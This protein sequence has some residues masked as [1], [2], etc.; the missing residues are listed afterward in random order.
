[1]RFLEAALAL[2][3]ACMSC[4]SDLDTGGP[5]R[6]K[7][8][9]AASAGSQTEAS[10]PIEGQP[11]SNVAPREN[12]EAPGGFLLENDPSNATGE[13]G[14]ME[15]NACAVALFQPREAEVAIE[16][17]VTI[18]KEV[19]TPVSLYIVLDNSLSMAQAGVN[20]AGVS[21][22]TQAVSSVTSFVN[23]PQSDG[24]SVALQY[25]NP[26]LITN[27]IL[28]APL[29]DL[30]AAAGSDLC[31]GAAHAQPSV[32]LGKL[33]GHA[34]AIQDSLTLTG[35]TSNT[36]ST[37]ALNGGVQFC[38]GAMK[39][40]PSQKCVVVFV[41]DGQPNGCDLS[42]LGCGQGTDCVDPKAEG[43]LTGIAK[44]ARSAGVDTFTVGMNGVSTAG[45]ELLN[46]IAVAGGTDCT[47]SI[48][49]KEACDASTGTFTLADALSAI[50]E[51]ISVTETFTEVDNV[52]EVLALECSWLL[53]EPPAGKTIDPGEVNLTLALN[54]SAPN[55]LGNVQSEQDCAQTGGVGWFY[56]EPAKPSSINLCAASCE[57]VKSADRAEAQVLLGCK[58]K[59]ATVR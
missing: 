32:P 15:D 22:W 50:R 13:K 25:F 55:V 30:L 23:D 14:L 26:P 35:P 6:E 31:T 42:S 33:P 46:A 20:T 38:Q 54:R 59:P 5:G 24:L 53:P 1:M 16:R 56:D 52:T 28:G 27:A 37:G 17:E 29:S 21:K 7:T 48:P 8:P 43:V 10:S 36:P 18:T 9:G 49:G 45:F 51:R 11:P 2:P 34:Q 19:L 44:S 41:T 57:A 12:T 39:A 58:T 47:T 3:L 4:G 40:D